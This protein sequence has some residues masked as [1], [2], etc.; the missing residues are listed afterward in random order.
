MPKA[1]AANAVD[2][3]VVAVAAERP[4]DDALV[5][6]AGL[7]KPTPVK[8]DAAAGRGAAKLKPVALA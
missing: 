5:V 2:A 6:V 7:A 1:G 3:V 4:K 8:L